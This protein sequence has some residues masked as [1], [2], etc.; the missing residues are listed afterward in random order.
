[1]AGADFR[2]VSPDVMLEPIP[3]HRERRLRRRSE[4]SH[5]RQTSARNCRAV[6]D[7]QESLGSSA[8]APPF[9]AEALSFPGVR[10]MTP[11]LFLHPIF[12]VAEALTGVPYC[13]VVP[14]PGALD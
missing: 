10:Q 9:P 3:G 2:D 5:A 13:E 1:M 8:N 11:D 6:L 7:S 14:P 4:R 12:D